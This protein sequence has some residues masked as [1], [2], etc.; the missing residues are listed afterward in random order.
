M[1]LGDDEWVYMRSGF[2][3]LVI[4]LVVSSRVLVKSPRVENMKL[5]VDKRPDFGRTTKVSH[6]VCVFACLLSRELSETY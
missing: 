2:E 4:R 3:L 6:A 1:F 5:F